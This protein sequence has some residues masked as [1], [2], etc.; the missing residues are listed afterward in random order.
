M[1]LPDPWDY[2]YEW[3]GPYGTRKFSS[4]SHNGARPTRSVPIF[5]ADQMHA[6]AAAAVEAEREAICDLVAFHGGSV[7]IEAT[8]RARSTASAT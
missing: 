2:C 6:Y 1:S 8:I 7:E 5:T 3:D 4:A